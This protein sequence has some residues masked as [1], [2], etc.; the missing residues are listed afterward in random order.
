MK[1]VTQDGCQVTKHKRYPEAT[2][3]TAKQEAHFGD[4]QD[5]DITAT[6]GRIL[7]EDSEY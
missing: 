2:K 4:Y 5:T 7:P 1:S 6:E 3:S